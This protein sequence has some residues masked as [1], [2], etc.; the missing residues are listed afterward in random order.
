MKKLVLLPFSIFIFNGILGQQTFSLEQCIDRAWTENITLQQAQNNESMA[1]LGVENSLGTM[2]PNLNGQA[3]HGYNWGQRIDPFTNQFASQR[4]RSNNFGL[5]SSIDL[6]TGGQNYYNYQ[7]SK[8]DLQAAHWSLEAT[9]NSVALQTANA[10]LNVVLT[11][12]LMQ[13]AQSTA[14]NSREQRDRV[15]RQVEAGTANAGS[16]AEIEAQYQ[17]DLAQYISAENNHNLAK[18][19]LSQ[20]MRYTPEDK[21]EWDVI[22][23]ELSLFSMDKPL[24]PK[25]LVLQS[26]LNEQPVVK[27][28]NAN[29]QS[30]AM[31]VESAKGSFMPR[32]SMSMSVGTGYSGAAKVINGTPDSLQFPIGTV[33]GTNDVVLSYPQAYYSSDDYQ[34]KQFNDQFKD[35]V[36]R[37]FFVTATLPLFNGFQAKNGVKRANLNALNANLNVELAEQRLTQ[38]VETAYANALAAQSTFQASKTSVDANKQAFDFASKRYQQGVINATEYAVQRNRFDIAKA[39]YVRAQLDYLFKKNILLFYMNQP[40]HLH[41]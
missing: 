18:L 6:F 39:Q 33:M 36:N 34:V 12:E 32:V 28:A 17:S 29:A 9:K 19:S 23:P 15:S 40:I 20:A 24:P 10:F 13:I 41:P 3:S 5:A 7:K 1:A 27:Q 31:S 38:D 35:N 26:A 30:A 21:Q 16:L 14:N 25:E 4:I 8:Y 11:R 37:S 2:L 22:Y